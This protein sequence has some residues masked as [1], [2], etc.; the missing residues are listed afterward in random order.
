[1][2]PGVQNEINNV[3]HLSSVFSNGL[4]FP[5]DSGK[6]KNNKMVG[7]E[8]PDLEELDVNRRMIALASMRGNEQTTEPAIFFEG[9]LTNGSKA[10][11]RYQGQT[12]TPRATASSTNRDRVTKQARATP[13]SRVKS[14]TG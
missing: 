10:K 8:S 11:I 9:I 13:R 7:F 2:A 5:S 3:K 1:M 14:T 12:K 4:S 6:S